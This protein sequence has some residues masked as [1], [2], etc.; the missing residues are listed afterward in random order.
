MTSIQYK[1]KV[2][3]FGQSLSSGCCCSPV[4]RQRSC[5]GFARVPAYRSDGIH[6]P[7]SRNVGRRVSTL[8]GPFLGMLLMRFDYL[9]RKESS[10]VSEPQRE[11]NSKPKH[12]LVG[13]LPYPFVHGTVWPWGRGKR[14]VR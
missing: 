3:L 6:I 13:V 14:H 2:G 7:S 4:G 10:K 12:K 11:R 1:G 5:G 9:P 8:R